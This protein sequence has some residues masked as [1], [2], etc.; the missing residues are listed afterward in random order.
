MNN[1][2]L[3]VFLLAMLITGAIDSIRNLPATAMFGSTL[4]FF[5]IFAAIVF[6]LPVALV[7]AEL[8]STWEKEGGI[9]HWTK[10]AFGPHV[11]FVAIWLQWINTMVW[12][13]TILSFIAGTFAF[14]INPHLA[15]NKTYLISVILVTFWGLTLLNLRGLHT[16]AKFASFCTV[17]GMILPM[18]IIVGL[19]ISWIVLG[20][21]LQ[22]HLNSHT[23]IPSLH[24]GDS[25]VS[26]TAIM[27]AFL[28]MELATV[29]VKNVHNP[30]KTFP[31]A[32][33]IS[34]TI[35]LITMILGALSIAFVLPVNKINL[36]DGVMQ[37]F[38]NFFNAYHIAWLIPVLTVM[39]LIG[40]LGGMI[41][42]VISPARGLLQAAQHGYLPEFLQRTNKHGVARNLLFTQAVL[43]SL[44]CLAFLLMPSV[45]GSYWLLTDLSTQLYMLMYVL[46][47]CAAIY[48]RYKFSEKA[49]PFRLPGAKNLGMWVVGLLGLFG[50]AIS[51]VIG[52]IPPANI[53]VGTAFHYIVMFSCGMVAMVVP[54]LAFFYYHRR[55]MNK[56]L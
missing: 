43:V 38:S 21:P 54:V 42:W 24:H 20:K 51:I 28:G 25:W 11:G 44:M 10:K 12:Y 5:F 56:Y 37:A 15:D 9:Y 7:S 6:L 53:N 40:S 26:L 22:I 33:F 2:N 23:I 16:S 4:I 41:N 36:V 46:M 3:S 32:L 50:C 30:K 55:M 8:S 49:R 34:V 35:I 14:F 19:A 17:V 47:F 27:A 18:I 29:H 48:L 1:R 52:F 13:P 39:I 45:N 31:K